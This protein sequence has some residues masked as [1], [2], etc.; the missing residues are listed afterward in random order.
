MKKLLVI[1][2][3]LICLTGFAQQRTTRHVDIYNTQPK[4]KLHFTDATKV[5]EANQDVHLIYYSDGWFFVQ[6]QNG[7]FKVYTP[8]YNLRFDFCDKF[9]DGTNV[10][11]NLMVFNSRI[12]DLGKNEFVAQLPEGTLAYT[13]LVDGIG[14]MKRE[15]Y[16]ESNDRYYLYEYFNTKGE[17][18]SEIPLQ[19]SMYNYDLRSPSKLVDNRRAIYAYEL[20][21]WGFMD[22][23][24]QLVI[25]P[26]YDDVHD[27]SEGLA[28]VMK[29]VDGEYRW[30][31][32]DTEGKEVIPLKF[33]KEPGDFSD[34]MAIV[35][36]RSGKKTFLKPDGTTI[37]L[38]LYDVMPRWN[39]ITIYGEDS[40]MR[41]TI[42]T[43]S[44][45]IILD[46]VNLR[47][48]NYTFDCPVPLF[49]EGR[50][51]LVSFKGEVLLNVPY[52]M[53]IADGLFWKNNV[54]GYSAIVFNYKGEVL[55][56]FKTVEEEF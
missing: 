3:A 52:S 4:Y 49:M 32:I 33:S 37:D 42:L 17:L 29:V 5:Y 13:E 27:F 53:Y 26:I 23:N 48:C 9:W 50:S 56:A 36:K 2:S 16:T 21:K 22:E 31:F 51:P 43:P 44:E 19:A 24:C 38:D 20:Q 8:E 11:D 6:Y 25:D 12:F 54:S 45:T 18:T 35:E 46:D 28:A 34:G 7:R 39:K 30:G 14:A 55:M 41:T 15:F 47:R 1:L 10:E 40:P